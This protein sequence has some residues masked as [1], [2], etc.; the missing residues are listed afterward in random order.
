MYGARGWVAHHNTDIW[1]S[2]G[3]VDAPAWGAWPMGG[4]WLTTHLWEH[5][6]FTGDRKFLASAYPAMRGAA[7][8]L[9]TFMMRH[10]KYGWLV[11]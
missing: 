7:E 1:R 2:P 6:L 11:T 4:A 10:P 5:W 9:L 8:F 3:M